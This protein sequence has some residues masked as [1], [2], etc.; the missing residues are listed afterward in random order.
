M[1]TAALARVSDATSPRRP[2]ERPEV[3]VAALLARLEQLGRESVA[4]SAH[5]TLLAAPG[6]DRPSPAA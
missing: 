4:L 2:A 3:L 1:T 6:P 5:Y